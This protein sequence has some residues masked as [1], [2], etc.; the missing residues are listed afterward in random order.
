MN[1]QGPRHTLD[2]KESIKKLSD[3]TAKPVQLQIK[4]ASVH[5]FKT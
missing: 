5:N 1:T 3:I 2:I 4:G